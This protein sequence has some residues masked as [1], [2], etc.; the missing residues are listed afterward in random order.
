MLRAAAVLPLKA[1]AALALAG[2]RAVARHAPGAGAGC[3][4]T[5]PRSAGRLEP[6][7]RAP[8]EHLREVRAVLAAA[9]YVARRQGAVGG[10]RGGVGR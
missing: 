9:A 5:T 8:D 7:E 10:V 3:D 6:L 4:E 1:I 2:G